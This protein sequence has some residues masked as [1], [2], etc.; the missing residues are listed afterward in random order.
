MIYVLGTRKAVTPF[1][2]LVIVHCTPFV[3]YIVL[4]K[5]LI[6]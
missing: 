3:V 2:F 6:R 1:V 4:F 5:V